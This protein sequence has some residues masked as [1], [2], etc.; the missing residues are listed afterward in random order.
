MKLKIISFNIKTANRIK[1]KYMNVKR[2]KIIFEFIYIYQ[3]F[4]KMD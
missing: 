2:V 1:T 3:R 4:Q